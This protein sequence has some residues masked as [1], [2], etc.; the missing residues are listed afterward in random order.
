[1]NNTIVSQGEEFSFLFNFLASG[2]K[3]NDIVK[4][5]ETSYVNEINDRIPSLKQERHNLVKKRNIAKTKLKK[6]KNPSGIKGNSIKRD[7]ITKNMAFQ[8]EILKKE[9]EDLTSKIEDL[10]NELESLKPKQSSSS[11]NYTNDIDMI[12]FL[13]EAKKERVLIVGSK[14]KK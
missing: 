13:G 1:M 2:R 4:N 9:I 11:G 8:R 5:I 14:N 10:E 6:I 3:E 7:N 12:K